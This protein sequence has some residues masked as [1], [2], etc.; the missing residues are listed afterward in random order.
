[1]K[2]DWHK[3]PHKNDR[4]AEF[5]AQISILSERNIQVLQQLM[6][7]PFNLL[8]FITAQLSTG[9][10]Q[11]SRRGI[12]S[13]GQLDAFILA[14][15]SATWTQVGKGVEKSYIVA[16]KKNTTL[17]DQTMDFLALHSC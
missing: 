5:T 14:F 2:H 17:L 3:N 1:M 16:I 6:T 4:Q 15:P 11:N 12:A 13:L 8:L 7:H 9:A 10:S